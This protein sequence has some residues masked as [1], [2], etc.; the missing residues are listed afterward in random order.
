MKQD[1]I[2]W[3]GVALLVCSIALLPGVMPP[4]DPNQALHDLAESSLRID[5][6]GAAPENSDVE[7]RYN[8]F[9]AEQRWHWA[10]NV[11]TFSASILAAWL[12]I[13][14]RRPGLW[15]ALAVCVAML[16]IYFPPMLPDLVSGKF[17]TSVVPIVA[18]TVVRDHGF[19][20]GLIVLWHIA[21]APFAYLIIAITTVF[22]L[23]R[24]GKSDE[25]KT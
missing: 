20:D 22:A 19:F 17:F 12:M 10:I 21:V 13:G 1:A 6:G 14:R 11:I 5:R 25:V 23:R 16:S 4:Q 3:I 24:R 2:F 15:V 8:S 9:M 7:K 18:A